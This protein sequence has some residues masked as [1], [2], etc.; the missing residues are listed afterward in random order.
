MICYSVASN[1]LQFTHPDSPY[2]RTPWLSLP[3][4]VQLMDVFSVKIGHRI[5][6]LAFAALHYAVTYE[7]QDIAT[8]SKLFLE[9]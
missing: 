7:R 5:L 2:I 1:S 4:N 3:A 8:D 6:G 9:V